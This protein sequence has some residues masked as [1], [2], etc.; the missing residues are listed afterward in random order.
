MFGL[1]TRRRHDD[2]T[3]QLRDVVRKLRGERDQFREERDAFRAA[4]QTGARQFAQADADN[5]RLAGR[6][7]AL[8]ERISA[9]TESDPG[10][11]ADMEQQ[12]AA[13][14]EELAAERRRAERLQARLDDAVGLP[15]S[16][17]IRDSSVWQPGYKAPR[18]EVAS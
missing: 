8:G 12:L 14:R 6:N 1:M 18:P 10:Y 2:E 7:K 13:V 15:A 16:G 11:L 17:P 9:L 3:A 5:R 4:A